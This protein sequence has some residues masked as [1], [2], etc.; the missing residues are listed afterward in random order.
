MFAA[1]EGGGCAG[2]RITGARVPAKVPVTDGCKAARPEVTS[3]LCGCAR[4]RAFALGAAVASVMIAVHRQ[5]TTCTMPCL[6][7][8]AILMLLFL[9]WTVHAATYKCTQGGKTVYQQAPC[10]ADEQGQALKLPSNSAGGGT[11][12][13]GSEVSKMRQEVLS[14]GDRMAKD[15]FAQLASGQVDVYVANLCPR[16][17]QTWS[18][19]TLKG[20]L[21][22]MGQLLTNDQ[23]KLG[24]QTEASMDSLSYKAVPEPGHA[25][26]NNPGGPRMRNVRAFFGRD[27]GQLCLRALDIGA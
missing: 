2:G 14:K 9:P 4:A 18:N 1:R 21:K 11:S 8:S 5:F 10:A 24:R 7:R 17:R 26:W 25:S 3:H 23:L 13:S 6:S 19:P 27:L 15:A 12:Y 16:E 20:S 22:S